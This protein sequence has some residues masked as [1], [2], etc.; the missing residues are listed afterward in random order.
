M[1]QIQQDCSLIEI[2]RRVRDITH[3]ILDWVRLTDIVYPIFHTFT[4]D[5]YFETKYK[6]SKEVANKILQ[7]YQRIQS[8]DDPPCHLDL[9]SFVFF[10]GSIKVMFRTDWYVK[11]AL[12]VST[13]RFGNLSW[14]MRR[15]AN[16]MSQFAEETQDFI[17]SHKRLLSELENVKRL[18]LVEQDT[19]STDNWIYL[20]MNSNGQ[21][22]LHR[23]HLSFDEPVSS[24]RTSKLPNEVGAMILHGKYS[25][26]NRH[27]LILDHGLSSEL[28]RVSL[29]RDPDMGDG[30]INVIGKITTEQRKRLI[31]K[32]SEHDLSE[33]WN[34]ERVHRIHDLEI[35]FPFLF[36]KCDLFLKKSNYGN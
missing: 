5:C 31:M 8:M 1:S 17:K 24:F 16:I 30:L 32:S 27:S 29:S 14:R 20:R 35:W 10:F 21:I 22:V 23:I 28:N 19:V 4:T 12:D 18:S 25:S 11:R 9:H 15:P 34:I 33:E 6:V 7:K 26:N 2:L 3:K 13:L 36:N